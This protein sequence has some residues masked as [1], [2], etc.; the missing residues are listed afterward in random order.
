MSSRGKNQRSEARTK[1]TRSFGAQETLTM[2]SSRYRSQRGKINQR[3]RT[4]TN[5]LSYAIPSTPTVRHKFEMKVGLVTEK[6]SIPVYEDHYPYEVLLNIIKDFNQLV[7]DT[8]FF[9][10]ESDP[11]SAAQAKI[12]FRHMMNCLRGIV[13]ERWNAIVKDLTMAESESTLE[14]SQDTFEACQTQL[15]KEILHEDAAANL[16]RY[17]TSTNK[18][19]EMDVQTWIRRV[20]LLN[21][22]LEMMEDQKFDTKSLIALVILQNL[23]PK[24]LTHVLKHGYD[25]VPAVE[26]V[27][28]LLGQYEKAKAREPQPKR[29]TDGRNNNYRS[30]KE[31]FIVSADCTKDTSGRTARTIQETIKRRKAPTR[32]SREMT[33]RNWTK[34]L[35]SL[36][37]PEKRSRVNNA[38]VQRK[39]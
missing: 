2:E 19:F 39:N 32:R 33:Y 21:S 9:G 5:D 34:R 11:T 25:K 3:Y 17:M 22:Y 4:K 30:R 7:E 18:P 29:R 15:V 16:K 6:L 13:K 12:I 36:T 20:E 35:E 37:S 28:L 27:A 31:G 8:E 26:D 24:W 38:H 1:G 10:T 23:P 14:Y